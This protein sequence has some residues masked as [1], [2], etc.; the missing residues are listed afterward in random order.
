MAMTVSSVHYVNVGFFAVNSITGTIIKKDLSSTTI[1]QMKNTS[2]QHLIIVN[3]NVPN[4]AGNPTVEAYLRLE[5]A[6]K[7]VLNYMDQNTIITYNQT[8]L[9]SP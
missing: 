7:Y 6:S 1:N 5:A 3:S 2:H 4:S 9:N 8:D